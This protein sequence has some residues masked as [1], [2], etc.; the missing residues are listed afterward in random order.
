MNH[1]P[2]NIIG[3]FNN[4]VSFHGFVQPTFVS[5]NANLNFL[6][7]P[8][9]FFLVPNFLLNGTKGVNKSKQLHVN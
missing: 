4:N 9:Y 2:L 6:K 5:S 8:S 7:Y 1:P 3:F